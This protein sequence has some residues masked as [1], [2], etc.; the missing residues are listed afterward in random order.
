MKSCT[1]GQVQEDTDETNNVSKDLRERRRVMAKSLLV[2][3]CRPNGSSWRVRRPRTPHTGISLGGAAYFTGSRKVSDWPQ[4]SIAAPVPPDE[5]LPARNKG[6]ELKGLGA[7]MCAVTVVE[8][9]DAP[10]KRITTVTGGSPIRSKRERIAPRSHAVIGPAP[11]ATAGHVHEPNKSLARP[12]VI[13][14]Q[15]AS[16]TTRHR[17]G[18]SVQLIRHQGAIPADG[19]VRPKHKDKKSSTLYL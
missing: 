4:V 12:P 17:P 7:S 13:E 5:H 15:H 11:V 2:I 19:S 18:R 9:V 3:F 8:R 10:E 1:P 16:S 6:K 14:A